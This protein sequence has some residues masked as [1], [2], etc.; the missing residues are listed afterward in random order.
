MATEIINVLVPA[1]AKLVAGVLGVIAAYGIYELQK[2]LKA[3]IGEVNYNK[4]YDVAQGL[5]VML[6]DEFGKGKGLVKKEEMIAK[7]QELFP[8]LTETELIAINKAVWEEFNLKY[9]ATISQVEEKN[10]NE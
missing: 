1:V 9:S 10:L 5:Y 2:W 6:E 4:A 8:T 7:L 3:K